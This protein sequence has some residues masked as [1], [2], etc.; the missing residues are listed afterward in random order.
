MARFIDVNGFPIGEDEKS[1]MI[2]ELRQVT[3]SSEIRA[4]ADLNKLHYDEL[5]KIS[6]VWD[7]KEARIVIKNLVKRYP[8]IMF[9]ELSKRL[10][11]LT[12]AIEGIMDKIETLK[13]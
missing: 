4:N 6:E 13:E 1:A 11:K 12:D 7:D 10:D 2:S 9:E 5:K 8:G 3:E